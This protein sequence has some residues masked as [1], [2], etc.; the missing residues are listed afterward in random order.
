MKK[1]ILRLRILWSI[2]A[3]LLIVA[4][5]ITIIYFSG[6]KSKETLAEALVVRASLSSNLSSTGVVKNLA[7]DT[8]V[9]LAALTVEDTETISDI[10]DNDY[11][12]N[13][14]VGCFKVATVRGIFHIGRGITGSHISPI[15]TGELTYR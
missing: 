8:S 6:R 15:S 2:V 7:F 12:V 4:A 9:P 1:R 13:L 5:V 11:T 14:I 3:A 10:I